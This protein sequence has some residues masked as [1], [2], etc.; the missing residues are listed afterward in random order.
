V[1]QTVLNTNWGSTDLFPGFG[2][3]SFGGPGVIVQIPPKFKAVLN[4]NGAI[5]KVSRATQRT[6]RFN[7]R[8]P[9]RLRKR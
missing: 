4:P 9:V 8:Q 3:P 1:L 6:L 2:M 7:P 5:G